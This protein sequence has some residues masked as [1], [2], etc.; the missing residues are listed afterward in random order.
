MQIRRAAAATAAVTVAATSLVACSS[1]ADDDKTITVGTTDDAKQAWV[2]FEQ[3]AKDAGYDIDIKSFSDYNT[4]NQALDQGQLTT[5]KFQHL[6]FLAKYNLISF[7]AGNTGAQ[8]GGWYRK[9]IKSVADMQ[10]LKMRISG[11]AGRVVEKLGVIPQQIAGG[12]IYP[13]L[14]RGVIDGAEYIGPSHRTCNR[15]AG[16]ANA[17]AARMAAVRA[18]KKAMLCQLSSTLPR[19]SSVRTRWCRY[20]RVQVPHTGHA[21]RSSSGA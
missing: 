7:P 11:L 16:Q 21:Q 20:A 9:E 14:E 6:Q 5:N 8:M 12:D 10:G 13:A 3:E 2:A 15:R 17:T 19:I 1:D 18:W 4:P